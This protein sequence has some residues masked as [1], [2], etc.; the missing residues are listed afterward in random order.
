MEAEKPPFYYCQK[1]PAMVKGRYRVLD[2]TPSTNDI[3]IHISALREARRE[4]SRSPS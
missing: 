3:I 1:S 2:I 4:A